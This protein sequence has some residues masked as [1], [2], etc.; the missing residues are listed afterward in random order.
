MTLVNT[1]ICSD[2]IL[3]VTWKKPPLV[4]SVTSFEV[5]LMYNDSDIETI[6]VKNTEYIQLLANNLE[7]N[8]IKVEA[9]NICGRKSPP[10]IAP[11][12]CVPQQGN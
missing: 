10:T 4:Q 1:P 6:T 8:S 2:D 11:I 5:T 3:N 12:T 7:I 9:V